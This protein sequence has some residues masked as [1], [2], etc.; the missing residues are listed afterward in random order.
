MSEFATHLK[1]GTTALV[2]SM[3]EDGYIK[4]DLSLE[5]PVRAIKEISHDISCRRRVR[6]KR[7]KELSAV[8]VQ[9]G[10][11]DMALSYYQGQDMPPQTKEILDKWEYVLTRLEDDPFSLSRELDWVIKR[12]LIAAYCQRK[13]ISFDDPRVF[14]LDLQ[15]HDIKRTRGLYYLLVREGLVERVI[16]DEMI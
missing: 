14:M 1:V 16:S 9:Q 4:R 2:L 6:L 3:V 5:D 7:G 13:G 8:E 12:E 15:Y 11:L 10:Y